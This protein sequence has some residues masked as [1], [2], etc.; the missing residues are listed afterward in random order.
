MVLSLI[1]FRF[2]ENTHAR[3]RITAIPS[4]PVKRPMN[5]PLQTTDS[6]ANQTAHQCVLFARSFLANVITVRDAV[7]CFGKLGVAIVMNR[8]QRFFFFHAIADAFVEFEPDG[9][10]DMVFFF[11]AA[12]AK[13]GQ[14]NAELLTV[15]VCYKT[16]SRTQDLGMQPRCWQAFGLIN[17]AL[18]SALQPNPLA[19]SFER[20]A[21]S[22]HSLGQMPAFFHA[23]RSFAQKKH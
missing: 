12:P 21:G 17:D 13:H 3:P 4:I 11:L 9:V 19:E 7:L 2:V 16:A 6:S 15:G 10:I 22:N 1:D 18:V 14:R 20:L 8:S 23:F 5:T